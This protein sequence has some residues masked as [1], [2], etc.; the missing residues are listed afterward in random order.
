[1]FQ[2]SGQISLERGAHAPWM[3]SNYP[4]IQIFHIRINRTHLC[5]A[6]VIVAVIL[7]LFWPWPLTHSNAVQDTT[8]LHSSAS[9]LISVLA[10]LWV[11]TRRR[12]KFQRACAK[13]WCWDSSVFHKGDSL[14][15]RTGAGDGLLETK[16]SSMSLVGFNLDLH[17][18]SG[19]FFLLFKK[20]L[21][22]WDSELIF[23][24]VPQTQR[25]QWSNSRDNKY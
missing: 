19:S 8:T 6:A 15:W 21:R 23:L 2:F 1:M 22:L 9:T 24:E 10:L 12:M 20:F 17:D 14:L 11:T 7:S 25:C 5:T 18:L 16:G 3:F 4:G 13:H